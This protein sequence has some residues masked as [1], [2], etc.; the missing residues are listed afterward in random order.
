MLRV[1]VILGKGAC[2]NDLASQPVILHVERNAHFHKFWLQ[3]P[4]PCVV[5][6][7]RHDALA[8]CVSRRE[9]QGCLSSRAA[10]SWPRCIIPSAYS[11]ACADLL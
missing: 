9:G 3:H 7:A 11:L 2:H 4:R 6:H 1:C 10:L 5:Q 8:F